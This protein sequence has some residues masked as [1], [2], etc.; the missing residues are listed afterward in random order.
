MY[1]YDLSVSSTRRHPDALSL[2]PRDKQRA[3]ALWLCRNE[4]DENTE[5][6][7]VFTL[8]LERK[9][10][11]FVLYA[12]THPFHMQGRPAVATRDWR[13]VLNDEAAACR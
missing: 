5:Y 9:D 2:W 1:E 12:R 13:A 10:S 7:E 3:V 6:D 4:R 11:S 8:C